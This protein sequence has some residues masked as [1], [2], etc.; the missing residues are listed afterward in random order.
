MT[1]NNYELSDVP[2]CFW[3]STMCASI[4]SIAWI[5]A[6]VLPI[7]TDLKKDDSNSFAFG[8]RIITKGFGHL[9]S[10]P[11]YIFQKC[12]NGNT[13]EYDREPILDTL[14]SLSKSKNI[15]KKHFMGRVA[16]I[17]Y[18]AVKI[19]L[20]CVFFTPGVIA[21]ILSLATLGRYKELNI[22]ALEAL[23]L[24]MIIDDIYVCYLKMVDIQ[25]A[26]DQY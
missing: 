20:R 3:C 25:A 9:L 1:T 5:P 12:L 10:G 26:I 23:Q 7:F 22:F 17:A 19:F 8:L 21:G 11:L 14:K 13:G 16:Q 24:P 18:A 4:L 6:I 2:K 15:F